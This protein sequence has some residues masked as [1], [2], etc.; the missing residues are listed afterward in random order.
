M[1]GIKEITVRFFV[2][3]LIEEEIEKVEVTEHT[4]L[5][6]EGVIEYERNTLFLNG[7]RQICLTKT[8][9]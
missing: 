7:V 4:F 9:F 6:A 3:D 2:Y 5:K 1:I 8:N